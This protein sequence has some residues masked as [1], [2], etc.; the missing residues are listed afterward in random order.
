MKELKDCSTGEVVSIGFGIGN[1]YLVTN[2]AKQGLRRLVSLSPVSVGNLEWFP[3]DNSVVEYDF[4][5]QTKIKA[6]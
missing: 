2:E 3:L 5:V 4:R 6:C 1:F